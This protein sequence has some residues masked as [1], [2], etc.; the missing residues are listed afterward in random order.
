[1]R[2][3]RIINGGPAT[4]GGH[5]HAYMPPFPDSAPDVIAREPFWSDFACGLMIGAVTT[6]ATFAVAIWAFWQWLTP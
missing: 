1:M 3:F 2:K 5:T 4:T 6:S